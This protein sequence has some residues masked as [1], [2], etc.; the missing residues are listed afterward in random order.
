MTGSGT[1]GLD[2]RSEGPGWR[3]ESEAAELAMETEKVV[4]GEELQ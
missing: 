3:Q 1:A 4:S 2:Y